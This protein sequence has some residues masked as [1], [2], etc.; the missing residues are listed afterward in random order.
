MRGNAGSFND[1]GQT[2]LKQQYVPVTVG[3]CPVGRCVLGMHGTG[4]VVGTLARSVCAHPRWYGNW[5]LA[6]RHN[7]SRF[8]VLCMCIV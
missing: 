7:K 4:G 2:R 3:V 6:M 5:E 8:P 1:G